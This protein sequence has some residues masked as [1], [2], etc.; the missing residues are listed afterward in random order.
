MPTDPPEDPDDDLSALLDVLDQIVEA[1]ELLSR[2]RH[3]GPGLEATIND[4]PNLMAAKRPALEL[5][6]WRTFIP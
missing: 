6:V 1:L 3:Q 4:D 2:S 5:V